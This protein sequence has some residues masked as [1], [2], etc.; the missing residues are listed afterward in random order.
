MDNAHHHYILVETILS[1]LINMALS[2]FFVILVFGHDHLIELWGWHSWAVDLVPQTI[3]ISAMSTIVPT[4]FT[5]RRTASGRISRCT[6]PPF[7][8]PMPRRLFVRAMLLSVLITLFIGGA[9]LL[10]SMLFWKGPIQFGTLLALKLAYGAVV[11]VVSTVLAL[12]IAL[13]DR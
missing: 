5:R 9:A 6:T 7:R 11:A 3:M 2:A 4:F 10:L 13:Y 12:S 8:F 1:V